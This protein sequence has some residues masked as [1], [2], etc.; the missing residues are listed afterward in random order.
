MH[1]STPFRPPVFTPYT[2]QYCALQYRVQA[3]LPLVMRESRFGVRV[4]FV[5]D[6][7]PRVNLSIYISIYIYIYAHTHTNARAHTHT[8]HTHIYIYICMYIHR[9]GLTRRVPRA[10]RPLGLQDARPGLRLTGT[11]L[12]VC[13]KPRFGLN[14]IFFHL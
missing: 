2:I 1:Y 9:F 6:K 11:N 5:E 13:H 12:C 10:G 3:K 8:T 14:K 7:R 4:L